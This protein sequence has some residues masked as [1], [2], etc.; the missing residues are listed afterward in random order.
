MKLHA[1]AAQAIV[2]FATTGHAVLQP[3]QWFVLVIRSTQSFPHFTGASA[4]QPFVHW[5]VGP[6]GAQS[7]AATAHC[8]LHAP[9]LAGFERSV[10]QP[11]AGSPLQFA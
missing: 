1:P 7:G 10:S 9:Q 11:S 2:A 4:V 5:K 3:P 6:A 8:A